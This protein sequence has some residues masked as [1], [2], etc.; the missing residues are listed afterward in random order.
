MKLSYAELQQL[1]LSLLGIKEPPKS[2]L[3]L[4]LR[5]ET[6]IDKHKEYKALC[7]AYDLVDA[8]FDMDAESKHLPHDDAVPEYRDT[9][10]VLINRLRCELGEAA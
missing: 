6:E 3:D 9:I 5:I 1:R 8:E 2:T 7:Y 4:L 10:Y